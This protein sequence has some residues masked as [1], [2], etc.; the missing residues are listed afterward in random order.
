MILGC[1]FLGKRYT[2]QQIVPHFSRR[3]PATRAD[4][5]LFPSFS[6]L[7]SRKGSRSR[8][9]VGR[10]HRDPLPPSIQ[11]NIDDSRNRDA[12]ADDNDDEPCE[13]N[14]GS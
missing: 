2:F 9:L 10:H 5:I 13:S 1:I 7:P 8:R 11:P 4:G 12:A 3:D 14:S 6:L